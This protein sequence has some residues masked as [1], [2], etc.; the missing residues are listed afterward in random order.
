[1]AI[2]QISTNIYPAPYNR[3]FGASKNTPITPQ[4]SRTRQAEQPPKNP[5]TTHPA[6]NREPRPSAKTSAAASSSTFTTAEK[7]LLAELKKTD[8][9][10]RQHEMAH[11]TAGGGVVTSGARFAYKRGPDGRNYAVAGEVGIDASPVPGDPR[12]TIRKMQQVKAAALAPAS[13]SAQDLKVASRAT[14]LAAK[15]A[16][17]LMVL[18]ARERA[19]ANESQAFGSMKTASSSYIKV[20][21]LPETDTHTFTLSV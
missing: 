13:P 5:D 3:N 7:L 15:A 1:M 19:S 20:N 6:D 9:Q 12:A 8:T 4:V 14:L 18:Q 16:S 2:N 21:A 11:V 10:V 17:E